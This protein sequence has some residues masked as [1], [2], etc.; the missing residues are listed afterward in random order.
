MAE[1][2]TRLNL[3]EAKAGDEGEVGRSTSPAHCMRPMSIREER[4]GRMQCAPSI[5]Y[6]MDSAFA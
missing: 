5:M 2:E 1:S 6:P 3:D 4:K